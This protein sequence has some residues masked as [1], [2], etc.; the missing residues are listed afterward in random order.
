MT[1]AVIDTLQFTEELEAAGVDRGHAQAIA[2]GINGALVS[3]LA[4]KT[5]IATVNTSIAA[6]KAD[7]AE[8]KTDIAEVNTKIADLR[9]ELMTAIA[10]VETRLLW[11]MIGFMTFMTAVFVYIVKFA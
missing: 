1:Q 3:H 11:R 4:T 10:A 5:D 8:V 6:V 2:R 9:A 7:I